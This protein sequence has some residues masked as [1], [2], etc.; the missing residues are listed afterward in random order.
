MEIENQPY[1]SAHFSDQYLGFSTSL[2]HPALIQKF[3]GLSSFKIP[4]FDKNVHHCFV[5]FLLALVLTQKH[6]SLF[7]VLIICFVLVHTQVV[8]VRN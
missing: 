2:L 3:S 1:F 8:H 5:S 7:R 4:V 6:L